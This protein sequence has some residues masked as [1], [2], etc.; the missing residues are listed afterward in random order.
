MWQLGP[1]TMF[2]RALVAGSFPL[3]ILVSRITSG[4]RWRRWLSHTLAF[5]VPACTFLL[6]G[7]LLYSGTGYA[8]YDPTERLCAALD[9]IA[10]FLRENATATFLGLATLLVS[11]RPSMPVRER[12]AFQ[13]ATTAILLATLSATAACAMVFHL[14]KQLALEEM[15]LQLLPDH[16]VTTETAKTK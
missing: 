7:S 8:A 4:R 6:L 13:V 15:H 2:G 3:L 12:K 9:S 11:Y 5:S 1:R 16:P 14:L 10:E